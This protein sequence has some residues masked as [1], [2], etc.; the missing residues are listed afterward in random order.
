MPPNTW[1]LPTRFSPKLSDCPESSL[2]R[3]RK[4]EF[5]LDGKSLELA[6]LF[7]RVYRSLDA[8][9]G[10]D[11]AVAA[12]W[13]RNANTALGAAPIEMLQTV[14]GLNNVI[15]YLDSRRARI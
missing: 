4:G 1:K 7:V 12:G 10:G 8:I 2:S 5:E 15:N 11:D 9:V 13:L 14:S 3:L 6:I